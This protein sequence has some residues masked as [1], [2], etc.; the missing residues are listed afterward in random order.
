MDS[1]IGIIMALLLLA[2]PAQTTS[3][4]IE[5]KIS[6]NLIIPDLNADI[7]IK[8]NRSVV[9]MSRTDPKMIIM[10][11]ISDP[12]SIY[13]EIKQFCLA[14]AK[15]QGKHLNKTVDV[16]Y[17]QMNTTKNIEETADNTERRLQI[18]RRVR[19]PFVVTLSAPYE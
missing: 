6:C 5:F 10:P 14:V 16:V 7:N 3:I 19:N 13:E 9:I 11:R 8:I 18:M 2:T 12:K 1:K 4:S 15:K 17:R